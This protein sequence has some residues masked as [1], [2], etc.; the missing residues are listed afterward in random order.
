MTVADLARKLVSIPSHED[1]TAAGDALEEWLR[2][3]T[4][5]DVTRD[6]VGNV[7]ARR[8]PEDG[9]SSATS[10]AL[11]GHHDVVPPDDEQVGDEGNYVVT[12][13]DGRLYGRGAET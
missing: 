5:A 13:R 6:A 10:L 8:G 3:E 12:E 11:V 4:D 7:I 1:E 9:S 2:A